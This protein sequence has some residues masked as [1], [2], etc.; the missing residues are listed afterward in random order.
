VQAIHAV[1]T[2]VD[3]EYFRPSGR[4][5]T[6]QQLLFTGS[7][8]WLPN[9]DAIFYFTEKVLPIV[10]QSLP[11]AHLV[12]AGR[13][14]SERLKKLARSCEGVTVT[15]DVPDMR[16]YLEAAAAFIVPIRI[17]GG[18]RLKIFEAMA[19]E[20]PVVSTSIGA[21]GLSLVPDQDLLI[22]DDPQRFASAVVKLLT[23]R[24]FARTLG[25]QGSKTV[26]EC[27]SWAKVADQF[28]KCC[29]SY[30]HSPAAK[31]VSSA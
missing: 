30:V 15:G 24:P 2:G 18:T 29:D 1:P 21:E 16:P 10:R 6:P 11:G 17:G 7:M 13:K 5:E 19:M 27:F 3:V 20:K 31:S 4:G 26:R 25:C 8:D 9:E 12:V 14:P 28:A 22:A 23:N